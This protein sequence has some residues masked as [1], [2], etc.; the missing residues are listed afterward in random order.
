MDKTPDQVAEQALQRTLENFGGDLEA[1]QRAFA[2]DSDGILLG[3][4]RDKH[5]KNEESPN[6]N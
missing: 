5:D 6:K 3:G 1:F 4:N 2:E